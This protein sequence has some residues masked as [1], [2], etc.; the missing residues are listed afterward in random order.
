MRSDAPKAKAFR[1]WAEEVLFD[2][3]TTGSYS[4]TTTTEEDKLEQLA[5]RVA[6]A[7]VTEMLKITQPNVETPLA[8]PATSTL[9][10]P[11]TVEGTNFWDAVAKAK[12]Y[13]RGSARIVN[14][15]KKYKGETPHAHDLM[16]NLGV[17]HALVYQYLQ[18]INIKSP[19][20]K[21]IMEGKIKISKAYN[22]ML[23]E[24]KGS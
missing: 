5:S 18:L 16:V 6:K 14:F 7:T 3:M 21:K 12:E 2:V 24:K 19:L 9:V 10:S 1:D 13:P 8:L 15:F 22:Q 17:S 11:N 23:A 20:V 4:A